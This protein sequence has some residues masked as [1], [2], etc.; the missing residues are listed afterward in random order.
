MLLAL[1]LYGTAALVAAGGAALVMAGLRGA[2]PPGWAPLADDAERDRAVAAGILAGRVAVAVVALVVAPASCCSSATCP[3][4]SWPPSPPAGWSRSARCRRPSSP[5]PPLP[6]AAPPGRALPR[7]R[8]LG[9]TGFLLLALAA[10]GA[11]A[12][13]AALSRADWRVLDLGPLYS[14]VVAV[15]LGGAHAL[16]WYGPPAGRVLRARLPAALGLALPAAIAVATVVGLVVGLAP[17]RGR[18]RRSGRGR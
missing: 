7:P 2:R 8:A 9:A 10:A 3:A 6:R 18:R 16:F 13:V 12:F 11:L 5:S 1:G 4:R 15:V 14:L 17:A